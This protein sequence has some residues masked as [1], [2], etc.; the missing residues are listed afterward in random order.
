MPDWLG[1][2]VHRHLIILLAFSFKNHYL[3]E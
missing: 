3:T 2:L 1:A